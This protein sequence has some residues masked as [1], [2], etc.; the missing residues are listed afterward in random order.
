MMTTKTMKMSEKTRET[1][2]MKMTT[3]I[4]HLVLMR[5]VVRAARMESKRLL[6]FS[7]AMCTRCRFRAFSFSTL[8][9]LAYPKEN[10]FHSGMLRKRLKMTSSAHGLNFTSLLLLSFTSIKQIIAAEISTVKP[11]KAVDHF[12]IMIA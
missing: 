1:M 4:A 2:W 3:M 11:C 9:F 5:I 8:I 12:K 10:H 6:F 7:W